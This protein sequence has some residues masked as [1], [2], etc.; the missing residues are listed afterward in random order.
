[1]IAL[2]SGNV[3]SDIHKKAYINDNKPKGETYDIGLNKHMDEMAQNV[4]EVT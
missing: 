2:N 3:D 4:R 1:M